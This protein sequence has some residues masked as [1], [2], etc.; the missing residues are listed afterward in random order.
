MEQPLFHLD[1]YRMRILHWL[2]LLCWCL[3]MS[4]EQIHLQVESVQI[5]ASTDKSISCLVTGRYA[6]TADD[7]VRL[8][9]RWFSG[10]MTHIPLV[11]YR[12]E[13]KIVSDT[14]WE[15]YVTKYMSYVERSQYPFFI[16]CQQSSTRFDAKGMLINIQTEELY[17]FPA[18]EYKEQQR[19]ADS[20][21]PSIEEA[22][23]MIQ[24]L[25]TDSI[26]DEILHPYK[27]E[28]AT[29]DP[30]DAALAYVSKEMNGL[31]QH[32]QAGQGG[33]GFMPE[34]LMRQSLKMERIIRRNNPDEICAL[35]L[36]H[37]EQDKKRVLRRLQRVQKRAQEKTSMHDRHFLLSY[38]ALHA[39]TEWCRLCALAAHIENGQR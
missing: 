7:T 30:V 5:Q 36:E 16:Q 11:F 31:D 17:F 39:E 26:D 37:I 1:K 15:A 18:T 3:P 9:S 29:E 2:V 24:A 23:A 10:P 6:L 21:I 28:C 25:Q 13:Q 27:E 8:T 35:A 19:F 32:I 12:S 34:A 38:T 33:G 14:A 20:S 22:E 4:A